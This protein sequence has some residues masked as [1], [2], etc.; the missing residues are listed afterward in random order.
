MSLPISSNRRRWLARPLAIVLAAASLAVLALPAQ[1][2]QRERLVLA[3]PPAAVS[4]PLVH[5]AASGALADLAETVEFRLWRDP[6]Q[7]R[8]LALQGEADVL[9]VPTNVAANL[10]NRGAKIALAN[11]SAWGILWIVS[12]DGQVR[13]L[14]DLKGKEI[15]MPFR[16][17]MP[18][19]LFGLISQ[20][21]GLDPR[22]DFSL[23]YVASPV[24]AMQLLLA[25]QVDHA[26]LAEP[27]VSMALLRARKMA[28][29]NSGAALHRGVDLQA[30]WGRAL[31]REPRIPQAGIA[32]VGPLREQAQLVE[33]IGTAY[34]E[35][36]A[37]CREQAEQCGQE[38]AAHIPMLDAAAVAESARASALDAVPTAAARGA[39][40]FLYEALMHREPGAI[41]GKLPAALFYYGASAN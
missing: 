29:G 10:Y 40:E 23:R 17:D 38:V 26:L 24:D 1:A 12:R 31:Q 14:A 3:G 22:R 21:E 16:G 15:A 30:E 19:L 39:L 11:V 25:G 34:A 7:L 41:G 28:G 36:L 20:A 33:R 8:V 35:A 4:F 6:D 32:V 13:T 5:M 9:A 37:W 2:Q 18:D 27:M